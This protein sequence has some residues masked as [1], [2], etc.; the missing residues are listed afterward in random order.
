MR[1]T[2]G[3]PAAP[4]LELDTAQDTDGRDVPGMS[5]MRPPEGPGA[6]DARRK[7]LGAI[8]VRPVAVKRG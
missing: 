5:D 4:L 1:I 3:A 6:I 8:E 7:P 2:L